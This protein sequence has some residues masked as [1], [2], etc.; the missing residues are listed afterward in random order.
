MNASSAKLQKRSSKSVFSPYL[1]DASKKRSA[2]AV[3]PPPSFSASERSRRSRRALALG[4]SPEAQCTKA[5][6][7]IT[8]SSDALI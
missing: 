5:F 1:R 2:P 7:S 4:R 6:A 8:S 3:P